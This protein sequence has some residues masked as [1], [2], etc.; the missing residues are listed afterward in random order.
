[1]SKTNV[2]MSVSDLM[3]GLMVIFLFVAVSY[4]VKVRENQTVLTDYVETR[5]KLHAKLVSEFAGDTA[6]WQMS[7]GKDLTMK[8]NNPGVLFASGE[9]VLTPVFQSILDEFLPRYMQILLADSMRT[10]IREIRVEGHT[11]D[12][13]FDPKADPYME[14]LRLSQ[15][16]AARVVEYYRNMSSYRTLNENDKRQIDYWLTANGMSYGKAL[17][18]DGGYV[19]ITHKPINRDLSRRVEIRIVTSGDDIL[20]NFVEKNNQ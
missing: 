15:R 14:N 5:T 1:M 7:I 19:Q 16:R 12:Q 20:V 17:D 13:W 3:T 6:R 11:D 9:D 8:F 4:M 18:M 2:W 10:Q